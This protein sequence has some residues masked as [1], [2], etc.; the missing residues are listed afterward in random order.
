MSLVRRAERLG[1]DGLKWGPLPPTAILLCVDMQRLFEAEGPWP[2]P[3]LPRIVPA[4]VSLAEQFRDR[5]VF[6][7]FMT[8]VRW[9]E[10]TGAWRRYYRRWQ[11][12]TRDRLDPA[13]FD[14][15]APL[16]EFASQSQ[17]VDKAVYSP[18][19]EGRLDALLRRT[20]VDTLVIAGVETDVCVL[21]TALGAIDRGY[22]TIVATDAICGSADETHD[23]L[24][25][26]Y[27]SRFSEQIELASA[28]E[29]ERR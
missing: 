29:I 2:V 1:G 8:P 3:W 27:R 9:E 28:S 18:W 13:L 15:I 16:S 11:E 6:T 25:T 21:A 5:S 12:V 10:A 17:I 4:V 20:A 19:T 23:A 22:R 7:R 26:L 24:M 14:I